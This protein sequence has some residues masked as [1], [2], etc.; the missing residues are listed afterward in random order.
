MI[1]SPCLI[2]YV[3]MK[4]LQVCG[5]NLMVVVLQFSLFLHEL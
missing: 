4:L 1:G 5:P 3:D 2:F